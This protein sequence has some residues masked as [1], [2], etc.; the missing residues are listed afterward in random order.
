MKKLSLTIVCCLTVLFAFG[1]KKVI[2][3]VKKEIGNTNPN[4]EDARNL[5]KGALENPET[6]DNPEAWYLAGLVENKQFDT[7][8]AKELIGQKPD[9]TKMYT[10]L[11]N[12][13]NYFVKADELDQMPNEKGKVKPKYRKDMK[14]IMLANKLYYINGGAYFFENENSQK[15]YDLFQQYIDIPKMKMFEGDNLAANDTMYSQIKFYAAICL[16]K[17]GDHQKTIAAYEGLKNDGYKE[18]EVYQYLCSEYEQ[19]KDTLGL[20]R[21]LK[22]GV[23]KFPEESYFILNLINQ[24]IYTNQTD[25]AIEYLTKAIASKPNDPQLHDVLGRIYENKKDIPKA[26]EC[27]EKAISIDPNYV[28]AVSNLGR[29]YFNQAVEDQAA[30]NDIS[31]NKKYEVAVAKAKEVFKQ[32]LPYFEKA[33]QMKPEERDYMI[34]LRGIYY[35]LNMGDKYDEIEKKLGNK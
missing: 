19:V 29:L 22:E 21:T 11:G 28:D 33:H 6:K 3:D 4:I 31:D 26:K 5:I 27:F 9:D 13:M 14:A 34:A 1:Q 2:G 32:A 10:G 25:E 15:A 24:Y 16:Y 30:A 7:E 23:E 35:N 18:N 12:I 20:I 17:L 8:R